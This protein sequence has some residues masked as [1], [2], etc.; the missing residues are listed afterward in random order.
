M[1]A[2]KLTWHPIGK[3]SVFS[4]RVFD[5]HEI[6]SKSPENVEKTFYAIH[7]SD[8]VIVIPVLKDENGQE[9]F[10]M[11]NQWRHAAGM[12]SVEFPGGVI[13]KGETPEEAA[14][15]ELREETGFVTDKL[16]HGGSISPNP[17]IM[18]NRCYIF[19]AEN[20]ENTH[21]L[22][23]D[24]DEYLSAEPIP[25]RHVIETMGHGE[26]LHGLMSAALF[27]Y[28]QKNGLPAR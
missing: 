16:V 27:L 5:I 23:L 15:R 18:D 2:S 6:Q 4:T 8:W 13:D 3:K 11:V 25:V 28:V 26:Y 12:M 9:Y 10:L 7:A 1:D 17:A 20:L 22:D 14:R 21:N 19:F 24:D